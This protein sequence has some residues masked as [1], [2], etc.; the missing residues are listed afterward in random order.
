MWPSRVLKL[1]IEQLMRSFHPSVSLETLQ[2]CSHH[3]DFGIGSGD[4]KCALT[5]TRWWPM[6]AETLTLLF[7]AQSAQRMVRLPSG[8][9]TYRQY[10]SGYAA[11]LINFNGATTLP[12]GRLHSMAIPPSPERSSARKLHARLPIQLALLLLS[13]YPSSSVLIKLV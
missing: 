13:L 5:R 1:L 11:P 6:F 8:I 2:T 10:Q 12:T 3:A 9:H 7:Y 4:G